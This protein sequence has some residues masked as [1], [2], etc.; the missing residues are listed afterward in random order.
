[1]VSDFY[2]GGPSGYVAHFKVT[3]KINSKE[4]KGIQNFKLLSRL[5]VKRIVGE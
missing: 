3:Q 4:K 2:L 1:M 5:Q